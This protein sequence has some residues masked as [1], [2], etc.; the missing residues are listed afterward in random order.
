MSRLSKTI[1]RGIP[2]EYDKQLAICFFC[3]EKIEKG[4]CWAGEH[5]IGVCKECS[6]NLIDLL[7]D[8]LNDS[9]DTFRNVSVEEKLKAI[10][11]ISRTRLLK[12]EADRKMQE[13]NENLKSLGLKYYAEMGIIDFFGFTMTISEVIQKIEESTSF[14]KEV[15]IGCEKEIKEFIKEIS[16]EYPH[17]IRFF[18]IPDFSYGTFNLGCVAKIDNN[19]STYILCGNREYFTAVDCGYDPNVKKVY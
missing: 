7:V 1:N 4:G 5:H 11:N 13:K 17:T 6:Y 12:K 15:L 9:D 16:G 10:E 19:G 14:R 3:G 8:T 2:D 18:P